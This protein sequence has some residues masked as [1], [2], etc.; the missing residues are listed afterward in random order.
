MTD[1]PS[2][3]AREGSPGDPLVLTLNRAGRQTGIFGFYLQRQPWSP[4]ARGL[5]LEVEHFGAL[6][7][8]S[9]PAAR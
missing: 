1:I 6:F 4:A 3:F 7:V 2:R 8:A 9:R 5:R